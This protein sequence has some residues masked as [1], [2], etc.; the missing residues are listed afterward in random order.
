[1]FGSKKNPAPEA[2][3]EK[4]V[5]ESAAAPQAAPPE[6]SPAAEPPKPSREA[7]LEAELARFKENTIRQLAE[8]ENARKRAERDIEE[9]RKFAVSSFARDLV[10]VADN[11]RRA[12][13]S[14]PVEQRESTPAMKNLFIGVEATERQLLGT[15]EKFGVQPILAMGQPFDP[16]FHQAMQEVETADAPPGTVV[17]VYQTGFTIADRLL[18]PALVVVA[19]EPSTGKVDTS[20]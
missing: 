5:E 4:P 8:V 17:Q 10:P 9:A 16:N 12:L 20:A 18:R 14:I 13:D 6:A 7:E 19:K 15:F 11:L 3:P 1:M 2:T